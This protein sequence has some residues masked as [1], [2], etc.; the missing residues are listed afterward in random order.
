MKRKIGG[1]GA[2]QKA[3]G[4]GGK[5]GRKFAAKMEEHSWNQSH[6]S[7]DRKTKQRNKLRIAQLKRQ[8]E[9]AEDELREHKLPRV[10]SDSAP[11]PKKKKKSQLKG[12][13]R[14]WASLQE[15]EHGCG[16]RIFECDEWCGD[17]W[18]NP[19]EIVDLFEKQMGDFGAHEETKAYCR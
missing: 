8:L 18:K 11:E 14:P 6:D 19:Q 9:K 3:K 7:Q 16:R 13:A 10:A 12:A 1:S 15:S 17:D 5:R 2:G 4:G